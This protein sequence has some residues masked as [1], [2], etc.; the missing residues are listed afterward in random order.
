[1]QLDIN[2]I[3]RNSQ[4]RLQKTLDS[5][6]NQ[7]FTD[8]HVTVFD[9]AS[10]DSTS[11]IVQEH[12]RRDSRF[13]YYRNPER[14]Y[15]GNFQRAFQHGN[16]EF[17][18]PKSADDHL[19]HSFIEKCLQR[20]ESPDNVMVHAKADVLNTDDSLKQT[21]P[22]AA[23][24]RIQQDNPFERALKLASTYTFAPAFW[25]IYRRSASARLQPFPFINGFDHI[26]LCEMALYG[27]IDYVDEVLFHRH[28]GASPLADNAK[29]ATLQ[30]IRDLSQESCSA[31]FSYLTPITSTIIGHIDMVRNVRIDEAMRPAFLTHL[32]SLL[33]GRFAPYLD[34]ELPFLLAQ[35][36]GFLAVLRDNTVPVEMR[37]LLQKSLA[38][39]LLGTRMA[40]GDHSLAGDVAD[41]YRDIAGAL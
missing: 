18:M 12:I 16:A 1:M 35:R 9:D 23:W 26:I 41:F 32:L 24:L 27:K 25:G 11:E 39:Q 36:Q 13:S 33:R 4:A 29:K 15:I 40:I 19:E 7:T 3:C 31:D 22:D 10:T 34:Q 38:D 2:L 20:L 17:V 37:L 6:S 14:L 21:Y 28:F 5:L 30:G 8:F